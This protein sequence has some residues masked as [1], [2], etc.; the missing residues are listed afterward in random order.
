M[1]EEAVCW[2]LESRFLFPGWRFLSSLLLIFPLK[3]HKSSV[4]LF[5]PSLIP[6]RLSFPFPCL[7]AEFL[8]RSSDVYFVVSAHITR[9]SAVADAKSALYR[10]DAFGSSFC[11]NFC[12]TS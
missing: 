1:V 9:K 3:G 6:S 5:P 7:I 8:C 4:R 2:I 12:S 11:F 10:Y